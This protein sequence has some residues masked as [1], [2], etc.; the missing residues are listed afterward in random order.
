[1]LY[2]NYM[3]NNEIKFL[4]YLD[5]SVMWEKE[6]QIAL[7]NATKPFDIDEILSIIEDFEIKKIKTMGDCVERMKMMKVSNNAFVRREFLSIIREDFENIDYQKLITNPAY[8]KVKNEVLQNNP[9]LTF[10]DDDRFLRQIGNAFAHGNYNS[11]LD[12]EKLD[13]LW[14]VGEDKEVSFTKSKD[15]NLYMSYGDEQYQDSPEFNNETNLIRRKLNL[16]LKQDQKVSDLRF[17]LN[18]LNNTIDSDTLIE[19][20]GFKYESNRTLD[21]KG[22]IVK[23]PATKIFNLEINHRQ[24]K[25]L[26]L[27]LLASKQYTGHIQKNTKPTQ[28]RIEV[29]PEGIS[30]EDVAKLILSMNDFSLVDAKNG[31]TKPLVLDDKQKSLFINEYVDARKWFGKDFFKYYNNEQ[32]QDVCAT[33]QF[34]HLI[35]LNDFYFKNYL[36]IAS[37]DIA[38]EST[39]NLFTMADFNLIQGAAKTYNDVIAD[40]SKYIHDLKSVFNTY[41]ESLVNEILLMFQLVEDNQ[42]LSTCENNPTIKTIISSLNQT[43][44]LKIRNSPKYKNDVYSILY[45]LRD[46]FSHLMYLNNLNNE[47]YIY[48]YTSKRNALPDFKF[49]ISIENLERIKNELLNIIKTHINMQNN[50]T[51]K[52]TTTEETETT[53][54]EVN[55]LKK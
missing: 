48:D 2:T 54:N 35:V 5:K 9:E 12:M 32:V 28:K 14:I 29:L 46:S 23:R 30:D 36:N 53:E 15:L 25:D 52:N 22:N 18:M 19:K 6:K 47:L 55:N 10:V 24:L 45:H 34:S 20:L 33:N 3:T 50:T 4:E 1:M 7:K 21:E 38:I 51:E 13:N 17:F 11:L 43:E 49:T 26:M 39:E 44:M 27:V 8:L 31:T 37:T 40:L 42:L 16:A 41:T